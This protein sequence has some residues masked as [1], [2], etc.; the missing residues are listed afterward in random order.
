MDSAST[1]KA[2]LGSRKLLRRDEILRGHEAFSE[3][4][5]KGTRVHGTHILG[6]IL[7]VDSDFNAGVP[8][9]VG[10]AVRRQ[11]TPAAD[12]NRVRRLM[13]EAYRVNKE[14]LVA[15]ARERGVYFSIVLLLK[16]NQS[17]DV[18]RLTLSD[19]EKDIQKTVEAVLT[20]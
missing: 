7:S 10:F 18:R 12:R 2:T 19:I 13:R 11:V 6:Y 3:I 5:G 14:K 8:V 16:A 9:R 4:L 15:F 20:L 1:G 17:T